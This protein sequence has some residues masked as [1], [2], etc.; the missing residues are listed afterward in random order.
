LGGKYEHVGDKEIDAEIAERAFLGRDLDAIVEIFLRYGLPYGP[1][2]ELDG[3]LVELFKMLAPGRSD[4]ELAAALERAEA[5]SPWARVRDLLVARSRADIAT[6]AAPPFPFVLEAEL[7]RTGIEDIFEMPGAILLYR[8]EPPFE[9]IRLD[10]TGACVRLMLPARPRF[11]AVNDQRALWALEGEA[12]GEVIF[13]IGHDGAAH[14][15][16]EAP[17]RYLVQA[18]DDG[19][20]MF[21]AQGDE[22]IGVAEL[23][24]PDATQMAKLSIPRPRPTGGAWYPPPPRRMDGGWVVSGVLDVTGD[25]V[26]IS[27]FD[28]DLRL[29]ARTEGAGEARLLTPVG[30]TTVLA[31]SI[32]AP[33]VLEAWARDEFR[34]VKTWSREARSSV[35]EGERLA[36]LTRGELMGVDIDGA[37]RWSVPTGDALYLASTG[38]LA[39]AY[40]ES[41]AVVVDMDTGEIVRRIDLQ[42]RSGVPDLAQDKARAIYLLDDRWLW[43]IAEREARRVTL[44]FEAELLTTAANAALLGD[45]ETGRY[46][47]IGSDGVTR[48]G[49]DAEDVSFSV[50]GTLGGPYVL[51]PGRLRIGAFSR[52]V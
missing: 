30:N 9:V 42:M 17:E 14:I 33:F 47:V 23:R 41:G 45:P 24:R 43:I 35:I 16:P 1:V 26:T 52:G 40:G 10:A 20:W 4:R 39:V 36:L 31:F 15:F 50:A 13:T 49:F 27:L 2:W 7:D 28:A 46:V 18:I 32:N 48:G 34:F 22:A 3:A 51:E 8:T 12:G 29:V 11:L 38:G 44:P 25:V 5:P 6:G 37:K 19:H 21:A